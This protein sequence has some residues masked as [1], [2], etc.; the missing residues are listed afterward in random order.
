M[1]LYEDNSIIAWD[2]SK[3]FSY[4]YILFR[5][6]RVDSTSE[7][8]DVRD[9][10]PSSSPPPPPPPVSPGGG[11]FLAPAPPAPSSCSPAGAPGPSG[12]PPP[13]GLEPGHG[14]AQQR[15]RRRR[16]RGHHANRHLAQARQ[17]DDLFFFFSMLFWGK[18]IQIDRLHSSGTAMPPPASPGWASP[19]AAG[20]SMGSATSSPPSSRG[21]RRTCRWDGDGKGEG[22]IELL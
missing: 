2:Q 11:D 13:G 14:H 10:A 18:Y 1:L 16:R 17:D 15:A 7:F 12:S 19:C 8:S 3:L 5:I 22:Q 9:A 4:M 6:W 20:S 21:R